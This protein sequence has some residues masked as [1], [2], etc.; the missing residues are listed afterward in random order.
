MWDHL[1][2]TDSVAMTLFYQWH[3]EAHKLAYE[4]PYPD[5][6]P[7]D[8]AQGVTRTAALETAV[9]DLQRD[10]C[11]WRV[12]W[13]EYVRLQRITGEETYGDAR[14]SLPTA[15]AE[16]FLGIL[17]AFGTTIVKGQRHRYGDVGDS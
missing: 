5:A 6:G 7:Q 17:F 1:S 8:L 14:P 10:F 9:A 2:T 13:H 3:R 12:P 4:P 16:P 15:G 11:A